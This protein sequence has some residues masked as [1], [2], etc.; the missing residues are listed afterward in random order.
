MDDLKISGRSESL[1]KK[2]Q[3]SF[4][5]QW[6]NF[7]VM[8]CDFKDNFLNYISPLEPEFF[9]NKLVLDAG[10][11]FGRH[12]YNAALFGAKMV[13]MDFSD[14]IESSRENTRMLR[15]VYLVKGDI[16]NPPFTD[17]AFDFVYSIGVLHH[18]P[19]PEKGFCSL[20]RFVK[21]GGSI[22]IWVYSDSRKFINA[23]LE[24]VRIFTTRMPFTLLKIICFIFAAL[25][26]LITLSFKLL[27]K[28]GILNKIIEK[29]TFERIKVYMRYPF[30]VT[31]ADWFDRLS[32]P[33]RF[34]YN[35]DDLNGWAKRAGLKKVIISPT[36]NYGWRLYGEKE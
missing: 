31:Y 28:I 9:K 21:N 6:R 36:G 12:L 17:K 5:F 30:Q 23:L 18:L 16:Y 1:K 35:A 33:I 7:S 8:S 2:T 32:A 4:S 22:F 15:N 13:G 26:Y 19:D 10:C 27:N 34:Y 11:G 24:S 3:R 25:D 14:A 20:L 29:I